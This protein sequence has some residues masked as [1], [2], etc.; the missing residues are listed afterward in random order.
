[1]ITAIDPAAIRRYAEPS[2]YHHDVIVTCDITAPH[3]RLGCVSHTRIVLILQLGVCTFSSPPVL[4]FFFLLFGDL[5]HRDLWP[6]YPLPRCPGPPP[7]FG[8]DSS[9]TSAAHIQR[10]SKRSRM[11]PQG[12]HSTLA[13]HRCWLSTERFPSLLTWSYSPSVSVLLPSETFPETFT[14]HFS[15]ARFSVP[16]RVCVSTAS[17]PV[18]AWVLDFPSFHP[19]CL[20]G[21][22]SL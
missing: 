2:R 16:C 12:N 18:W 13:R 3:T 15:A 8:L 21:S 11:N 6:R 14:S 7:R 22:F 9:L 1:M 10:R 19:L 20:E 4:F 5:G 17:G